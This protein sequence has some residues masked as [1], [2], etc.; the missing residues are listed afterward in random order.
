M[1]SALCRCD[2]SSN[3]DYKRIIPE[4][5]AQFCNEARRPNNVNLRSNTIA[6]PKAG[7]EQF[8]GGESRRRRCSFPLGQKHS[9]K[10]QHV[11]R[12]RISRSE[13]FSFEMKLKSSR[14]GFDSVSRVVD[15]T[16][17]PRSGISKENHLDLRA[18]AFRL[19]LI[20]CSSL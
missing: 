15:P 18:L 12:V 1:Q 8:G 11:C 7:A 20:R 2:S 9:E 13:I 5:P 14:T 16:I 19:K 10:Q 4:M 6:Y 17:A 3:S